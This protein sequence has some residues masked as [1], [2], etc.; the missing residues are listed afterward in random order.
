M[1]YISRTA[2]RIYA[3][4]E[5]V[6][7]TAAA[8]DADN[9]LIANRLRVQQICP[10]SQRRDKTGSRTHSPATVAGLK[11]TVYQISSY[12]T[13]AM[14]NSTAAGVLF[15]AGCGAQAV[16]SS[17]LTI[18]NSSNASS[19][20]TTTPHGL[21]YGSPVSY[22]GEIRFVTGVPSPDTVELNAPLSTPLSAG[23]SLGVTSLFPLGID[24][25]GVTLYDYWDPTGAVNRILTGAVVDTIEIDVL[26]LQDDVSFIGRAAELVDSESFTPGSAGLEA[27]PSEPIPTKPL[28]SIVP[29]Q[30]GQA[31]IG[32]TPEQFFTVAE[33]R[34]RLDN[35]SMLR[36]RDM[37]AGTAGKI[38]P[39][40]RRVTTDFTIFAQ[41]DQQTN[42]LYKIA[43]QRGTISVM[44]QFGRQSGRMM[45]LYLPSVIPE[46]P[47][48]DDSTDRLG[49]QFTNNFAGGINNDE[50]Y[51]AFA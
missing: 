24:L 11:T 30:S 35:N 51:I 22:G 23:V 26:G 34:V 47:V 32:S 46:V 8:I 40:A 13:S 43:A 39:G 31:W 17:G 10:P 42:D 3:A 37:A 50:L 14:T 16:V 27:F 29:S 36:Q 28:Y 7:G 45:A 19:I 18:A 5:A 48:F 38:V 6:Y 4:K 20:Q 41:N 12:L 21:A 2:N 44:L 33:A 15:A 9:R 25:N 1:S 49:W